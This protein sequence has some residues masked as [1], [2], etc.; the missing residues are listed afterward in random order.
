MDF[1][2]YN[3]DKMIEKVVDI[4]STNV[5][6][7]KLR[8]EPGLESDIIYYLENNTYLYTY[9]SNTKETIE[10][11]G[12]NW[13]KVYL[14]N[15]TEG[16]VADK[17]LKDYNYQKTTNMPYTYQFQN[18]QI[19]GYFGIDVNSTTN[20]TKFE[21]LLTNE[22]TYTDDYP[23]M[24][25]T[26]KVDFAMIKIGATANGNGPFQIIEKTEAQ[27]K[28][29]NSLI[30][31]CEKTKTNFGLYYY[32]QATTEEEA[33]EEIK[34]ILKLIEQLGLNSKTKKTLPLYIDVE[35][36]G[37]DKG[38]S[39]LTRIYK[40]AQENGKTEQTKITN[41]LMEELRKQ[42]N[43]EICLYTDGNTLEST[44]NFDEL[45]E[46]NKINCWI[47]ESTQ[48]HTNILD[49]EIMEYAKTRQ[50]SLDRQIKINESNETINVDFD[51]MEEEFYK[52]RTK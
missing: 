40:N 42:T 36:V 27:K 2:E 16:Y 21:K 12:Y 14:I 28:N 10:K 33:N 29:L 52:S 9:E 32:S 4:T 44:I 35:K 34:T 6:K 8:Q 25:Q 3:N 38:V 15:G 20:A 26:R 45:S 49:P 7:L 24:E 39:Y 23:R 51:I 41:Y 18:D 43:M 1:T 46:M 11:D 19:K 30:N 13:L 50:T 48:D 37:R 17:Y 22:C 47:V 31:I 5:D